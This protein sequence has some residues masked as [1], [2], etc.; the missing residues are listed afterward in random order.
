M[1]HPCLFVSMKVAVTEE[2]PLENMARVYVV[3]VL[4]VQGT[5]F[6]AIPVIHVN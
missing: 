4:L 1:T 5:Q 3:F 2:I 6:S